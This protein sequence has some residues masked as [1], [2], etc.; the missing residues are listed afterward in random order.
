MEMPLLPQIS[1][2]SNFTDIETGNPI[3]WF[4]EPGECEVSIQTLYQQDGH[5]LTLVIVERGEDDEEEM[6]GGLD[7]DMPRFGR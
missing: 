3:D 4:I 6:Q 7:R 5:A 2:A 1:G